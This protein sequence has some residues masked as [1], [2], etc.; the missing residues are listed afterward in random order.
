MLSAAC[1]CTQE[2][3]GQQLAGGRML[4]VAA[5]Q[6]EML[7]LAGACFVGMPL[8]LWRY[9]LLRG[10]DGFPVCLLD[11]HQGQGGGAEEDAGEVWRGR[12]A[13]F[14]GQAVSQRQW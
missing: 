7:M 12:G 6:G 5:A 2:T 14:Q 13:A 3:V 1:W 9:L 4:L 10:S 11:E 8:S